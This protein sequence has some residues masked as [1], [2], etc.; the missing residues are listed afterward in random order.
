MTGRE[1]I[2]SLI[3]GKDIDG[4]ALTTLIDAGT[5]PGFC[6]DYKNLPAIEFYKKIGYD[7]FCFGNAGLDKAPLLPY[8]LRYAHETSAAESGSGAVVVEQKMGGRSLKQIYKNNRVLKYNVETADDLKT[9]IAIYE[10]AQCV[11]LAGEE[12]EKSKKSLED[13]NRYT[14]GEDGIYTATINPSGVQTL[15]EYECGLENFYYLLADERPLVEHAI[16]AI[17]ALR[18]KEYSAAA[19]NMDVEMVIPVENTSTL[20]TSPEIYKRYTLGHIREYTEIAHKYGKKSVVHMCGHLYALL[21]A[22]KEAKID[23][24]HALTPPKIGD[25]PLERALDVLGEDLFACV[26]FKSEFIQ[27][28]KATRESI[29]A[30]IR[31]VFTPRVKRARFV[32]WVQCDGIP[33]PIWKFEAVRDAV[34]QVTDM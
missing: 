14:I 20:L 30:Y 27:D 4:I 18:R 11:T 1:R 25:C 17:Q 7:I 26:V 23:G 9:L 13:F 3:H 19:E 29:A 28:P 2:H 21:D 16:E 31:S 10:A 24:I 6:D 12:L 22:F 15:I 32:H 5:R 8:F 33:T 34:L